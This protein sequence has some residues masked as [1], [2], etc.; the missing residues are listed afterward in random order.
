MVC[1]VIFT[2]QLGIAESFDLSILKSRDTFY[3]NDN[4]NSSWTYYQSIKKTFEDETNIEILNVV[5]GN[6][7]ELSGY[8]EFRLFVESM[9]KS[10]IIQGATIMIGGNMFDLTLDKLELSDTYGAYCVLTSDAVSFLKS[11]AVAKDFTAVLRYTEGTI[12]LSFTEKEI[13]P[14]AQFA[15]DLLKLD[16]FEHVD[17]FKKIYEKE[18]KEKTP[19]F[20]YIFNDVKIE[21][22]TYGFDF[23][24]QESKTEWK[25]YNISEIGLK[26]SLPSEYLVYTRGMDVNDPALITSGMS[27]K[28]LDKLMIEGNYYLDASSDNFRSDIFITMITSSFMDFYYLSDNDLLSLS[29]IWT[30]SY[31]NYGVTVLDTDIFLHDTIKYLRMHLLQ[32][33]ENGNNVYKMQYYT[34]INNSAI[35]LV[36][37]SVGDDL[38]NQEKIS[39]QSIIERVVYTSREVIVDNHIGVENEY[40]VKN[41]NSIVNMPG[42]FSIMNG[43]M[44]GMS[45]EK[46][47]DIEKQIN[48]SSDPYAWEAAG[49]IKHDS[50]SFYSCKTTFFDAESREYCFDNNGK[51]THICFLLG[52]D[53][54]KN[55]ELNRK[56]YESACKKLVS[57]YGTPCYKNDGNFFPLFS[58]RLDRWRDSIQCMQEYSQWV[59][60]YDD[61]YVLSEV[62]LVKTRFTGSYDCF[63]T[64]TYFTESEAAPYLGKSVYLY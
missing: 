16:Y 50:L 40:D 53:D 1:L 8:P 5:W 9:N 19:I 39:M 13:I 60:K 4:N 56:N 22:S 59:L 37:Q 21:E 14:I 20:T 7:T 25:E 42:D 6:N 35:N 3:Y 11:L 33:N 32:K 55:D 17:I 48:H 44:F 62:F 43:I 29:S 45:K 2:L 51:L 61:Y 41:Y 54:T 36:Y 12:N 15:Y 30:A 49:K 23:S 58:D 10:I 31:D 18:Y 27:A 26:V 24:E 38:T 34:T 52:L 64:F 63:A 46:I 28:E 57:L 47:I